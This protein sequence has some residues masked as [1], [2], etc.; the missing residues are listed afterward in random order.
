MVADL[1][2]TMLGATPFSIYLTSSPDQ[3]AYVVRDA[4][5]RIAVVEAPFAELM[6]P[7]VEHTIVVDE[8]GR[9]LRRRLRA[10]LARR[11]ARRHPH[12]DLHQ[13][14]H[15]PA[16]GRPA[17]PPQ[18]DGG[19]RR[20]RE[21][22]RLPGRL[23]GDL[24][25]A[26][27]PRRRAHRPSLPADRLRDDDHDLPRSAPD[28]RVPAGREPDVVLRRPARV[29]EAQGGRRGQAR[30]ER[31]RAEA[32]RGAAG[33]A[34]RPSRPGSRCRELPAAARRR[35]SRTLRQAIGLDEAKLVNVGAAP[36]PRE[37]LV[38]FHAIGVPLAEI[39]GMSETC[40][41]G[42]SNPGERIKIGTVGLPSP[43]VE[44]KLARGRRAARALGGGDAR[45]PQ[46]AAGD[47][48]RRLVRHRRRGHD[49]RGRLRDD[50]GPQEGADH[51]RRA[52]RTCR[53]RTSRPS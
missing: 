26:E 29:G 45:L 47:R 19:R 53:R 21:A 43:G 16:E 51:Q 20:G 1:A 40:G 7:L 35:S 27:R 17:R 36:T 8:M 25:A 23:A 28:R 48:R 42:A 33:G 46:P 10:R 14:H 13:R 9:A 41:A 24:V 4:G 52:A 50:R 2:A 15:R 34:W 3:V 30:R 22:R 5:A 44:L 18:P 32:D 39:W 6:R 12:A 49:R 38:F 31:G 11:R 37:V